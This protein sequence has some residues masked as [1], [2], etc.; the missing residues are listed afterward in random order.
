MQFTPQQQSRIS[1]VQRE[2][3]TTFDELIPSAQAH[4]NQ[5]GS[6]EGWEHKSSSAIREY[7]TTTAQAKRKL[8]S[9]LRAQGHVFHQLSDTEIQRVVDAAL[10]SI[11]S[12]GTVNVKRSLQTLVDT[13]ERS[14]EWLGAV[15]RK[16][17]G[18][19]TRAALEKRMQHPVLKGI[20][21]TRTENEI[22]RCASAGTLSGG[23]NWLRKEHHILERHEREIQAGKAEQAR[24][25]ELIE[26]LR[27]RNR[28]ED[29]GG[30]VKDEVLR[31]RRETGKGA[32]A[33]SKLLDLSENT[34]KAWIKRAGL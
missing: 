18:K 1:R 10:A 24:Q 13:G 26:A 33:I 31:M 12:T 4:I 16:K 29:A 19:R 20:N 6:L 22:M 9:D 27:R 25:A 34:C 23:M 3:G 15:L 14:E 30:T 28:I 32:R 5:H 8:Y 11:E 17:P 7:L 2:T 21:R